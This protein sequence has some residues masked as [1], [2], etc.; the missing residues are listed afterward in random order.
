MA[1][2]VEFAAK[3]LP[4]KEDVGLLGRLIGDVLADQLGRDFLAFTE[5]V[6]QR[7][8]ARR[9]N[10]DG[11]LDDLDELLDGLDQP[12]AS[13]LVRAFSAYFQVVNLA[14]QVHRI[15][16]RRD[17]QRQ[18][19]SPQ[20]GG[21]DAVLQT[22]AADGVSAAQVRQTLGHLCLEPVFTA[23][24]T[25]ATRRSI[26]EKEQELVRLLV[27]RL[28]PGRTPE[29]DRAQV[30]RMRLLVTTT[31]QTAEYSPVRPL[32]EDRKSTV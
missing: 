3:D 7:A 11:Q 21:F 29:E 19:A 1:R 5:Q 6:R 2:D 24:P 8:I 13:E 4:L 26:L 25:E 12:R 30:E 17:Y 32:V 28:D 16:R 15:R 10:G 31:W 27:S 20:P 23:H 9:R 14:E 18:G 22:M